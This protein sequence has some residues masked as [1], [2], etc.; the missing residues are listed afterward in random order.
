V[1]FELT[2]QSRESLDAYLRSS[3]RKPRRFCFRVAAAQIDL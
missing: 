2:E 1:R 3:R